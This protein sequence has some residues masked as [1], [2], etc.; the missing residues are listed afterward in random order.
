MPLGT[1]GVWKRMRGLR[2]GLAAPPS[3]QRT[4]NDAWKRVL[5]LFKRRRAEPADP[6]APYAMVGAPK[7]PRS[8]VRHSSIAVEPER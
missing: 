8:P 6:D 5:G 1:H 2:R 3:Y 7:K 4:I